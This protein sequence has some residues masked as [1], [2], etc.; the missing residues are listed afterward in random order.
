MA[1]PTGQLVWVAPLFVADSGT[2]SNGEAAGASAPAATASWVPQAIAASIR[3]AS[4]GT[5]GTPCRQAGRV[6]TN[7]ARRDFWRLAVLALDHAL[8]GGAVEDRDGA[9]RADSPALRVFAV[10]TDLIGVRMRVVA[11][12]FRWRTQLVRADALLRGLVMRHGSASEGGERRR[13]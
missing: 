5:H 1:M 4:R 11:A 13:E 7:F 9:L 6:C 12:T 3:A 2:N 8:G 10:R